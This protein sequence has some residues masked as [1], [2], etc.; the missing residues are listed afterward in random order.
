MYPEELLHQILEGSI[1]R[2]GINPDLIDDILIG[3]VL[4]TLG[5]QKASALTVKAAG[6]PVKTTVNTANRQCASSSQAL[7]YGA[8]SI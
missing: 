7:S 1:D 2:S 8:G 5:G 3:T 4:Q 6:F